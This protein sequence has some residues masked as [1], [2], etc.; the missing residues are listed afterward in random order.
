MSRN[1]FLARLWLSDVGCRKIGFFRKMSSKGCFGGFQAEV[2][3][4]MSWFAIVLNRRTRKGRFY[5]KLV[6]L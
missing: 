2:G 3:N 1:V 5:V 4:G 6:T